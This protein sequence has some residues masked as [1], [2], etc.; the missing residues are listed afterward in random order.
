MAAFNFTP[1]LKTDF[2]CVIDKID[3]GEMRGAKS[4]KMKSYCG[5]AASQGWPNQI[6]HTQI[7][8]ALILLVKLGVYLYEKMN[9]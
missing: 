1:Q 6:M 4:I 5:V 8:D 3:S 9:V 2:R 7:F